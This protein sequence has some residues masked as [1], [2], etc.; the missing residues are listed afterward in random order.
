MFVRK[1]ILDFDIFQQNFVSKK[2]KTIATNILSP[3]ASV[4]ICRNLRH[5]QVTHKSFEKQTDK[6]LVS[7][8]G[9]VYCSVSPQPKIYPSNAGTM[10]AR[11]TIVQCIDQWFQ[12]L[13]YL[14][15]QQPGVLAWVHCVPCLLQ[16]WGW[17]EICS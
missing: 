3:T 11:Q 5:S 4:K 15:Q 10:L 8:I 16:Y 6:K 9:M 12:D 14:P 13:D 1:L 2:E 7:T 17:T